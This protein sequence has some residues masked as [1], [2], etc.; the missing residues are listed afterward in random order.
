MIAYTQYSDEG[1]FQGDAAIYKIA[2]KGGREILV[3]DNDGKGGLDPSW[4]SRH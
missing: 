2:A 4:G 1:L 3:T